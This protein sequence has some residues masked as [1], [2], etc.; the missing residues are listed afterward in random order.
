MRSPVLGIPVISHR[1]MSD[2]R[3]PFGIAIEV[4]ALKEAGLELAGPLNQINYSVRPQKGTF[5][6]HVSNTGKY[7][8]VM[9]GTRYHAVVVDLRD[10]KSETWGDS[11]SFTLEAGTALYV[12]AGYGNAGQALVSN[13]TYVYAL[14]GLFD[15]TAERKV[16][17]T[18]PQL[19]INW[20]LRVR[21]L[22]PADTNAMSYA[23]Y[24]RR[25]LEAL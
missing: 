20:P 25:R 18:D 4:G 15:P 7:V 23:E 3:G 8:F 9:P 1:M 22:S 17:A 19:A 12:P 24:T 13:A 14:D 6:I 21:H 16:L 2:K 11:E 10:P 5:G